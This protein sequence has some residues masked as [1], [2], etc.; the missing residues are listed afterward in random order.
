MGKHFNSTSDVATG[1][2]ERWLNKAIDACMDCDLVL[3]QAG[4]DPHVNDPLGGVLTSQQ[5]SARDRLVFE[6]LGRRALVW[7]LA[8]GYQSVEGD[9]DAQ[10]IEPV[11]ALHRETARLHSAILG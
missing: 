9:T 4:A 5:M 7:N 1:Q 10:R 8:G 3:Y 6:R 2:F 11:L